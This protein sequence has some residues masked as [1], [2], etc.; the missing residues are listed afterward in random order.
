MPIGQILM[1]QG[2]INMGDL[3]LGLAEQRA[4][5]GR[6]GEVL[7]SAA[8]IDDV[9]LAQALA[10]QSNLPAISTEDLEALPP[11]SGLLSRF[12]RH[13][14]E[15]S[16]IL[17]LSAD[18]S[19]RT[20]RLAVCDPYDER[21]VLEAK[22][23]LGVNDVA[24]LVA[25]RSA[26]RDTLATWYGTSPAA[27]APQLEP[28]FEEGL[29]EEVVIDAAPPRVLIAD[30]DP[31]FT[32][33][34]AE[35]IRSEGFQVDVVQDGKAARS[36]LREMMPTV[37][38]MD[39]ALPGIDG[40][41]LLLELR[42]MNA[43]AAVFITSNRG[44]DFRQAKAIE[45]GADDFLVKPVAIEATTS[46]IRRE[47]QRRDAGPRR[48]A[49]ATFSG[50]SGSLE[51]MTVIDIA[52]SL[53]LGRKTA[54][55][56]VQ[57]EDGRQGS[58]RVDDGRL[59]GAS[60][61][62]LQGENAFYFLA[63]P[64]S[65]LF[66]IEYRTSPVAPSID[67]GNTYLLIEAMRHLDEGTTPH[68]DMIFETPAEEVELI[69]LNSPLPVLSPVMADAIPD[70]EITAEHQPPPSVSPLAPPPPPSS[71]SSWRSRGEGRLRAT[72]ELAV[73]GIEPIPLSPGGLADDLSLE[74]IAQSE[75]GPRSESVRQLEE[76]IS[77]QLGDSDLEDSGAQ[78]MD[79]PTSSPDNTDV[80][81]ISLRRV[82]KDE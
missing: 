8:A 65:G 26:I 1:Q 78:P 49:P 24:L 63:K 30:A 6:I 12:P 52:Q 21:G 23:V 19:D 64:G 39:A 15:A 28:L 29:T 73:P 44:D 16:C 48:P 37:A 56:V 53:E 62:G 68:P 42:N 69:D 80:A 13:A 2:S 74:S 61:A 18:Q 58:L 51:D 35:R 54:H 32:T 41:N 70:P 31:A 66:R 67:V 82:L 75:S 25:P 77:Q 33:E 7:V 71:S 34:L 40:Y 27:H 11:P 20:V 36:L 76:W 17:P 59:A 22:V 46:K 14:A 10:T 55:V 4:K 57:Y 47:I 3:E 60:T 79:S 81:R 9:E 5:G 72:L 43:D 45:L 38:L 50:V